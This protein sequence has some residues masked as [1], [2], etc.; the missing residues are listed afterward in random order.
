MNRSQPASLE[1]LFSGCQPIHECIRPGSFTDPIVF[2]KPIDRLRRVRKHG[3]A[4]CGI[5][6]SDQLFHKPCPDTD[7]ILRLVYDKMF[8]IIKL[9]L[10]LFVGANQIDH[11]IN[12]LFVGSGELRIRVVP[13]VN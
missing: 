2:R 11:S 6:L 10:H 3:H 1:A 9:R 12:V 5:Q 8:H 4:A 13:G 7:E